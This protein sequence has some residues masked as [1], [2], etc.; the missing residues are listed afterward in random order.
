[1]TA[2]IKTWSPYQIDI[3]NFVENDSRNGIVEAVAGSGKSATIKEAFKRVRG[4]AIF[5]AFNKSIADE[6]KAAGVNGRTFHSLCMMPVMRSRGARDPEMN[7]L[8]RLCDENFTGEE[9]RLYGAFAQRLVG[10]ARQV[11]I[12][13]LVP[14]T[15]FAWIEICEH[16]AIE[17]ESEEAEFGKG[18]EVARR[19]LDLSNASKMVDFDDMLYFAVKDGIALPKFDFVFV[20]EAQDTNAIQRAILRKIM[21]PGARLVAVGDPAQ[22]I[23]GFRGADSESLNQIALDFNAVRLP[24]TITYRCPTSVVTYAQ[25]WVPHIEAAPGKEEGLVAEHGCDWDTSIFRAADLVVCRKSAP[26]IT[27][28]FR[29]IRAKVP[30]QVM[31]RDIGQG[32]KALIK[33]MNAKGVDQLAAKLEKFQEREV[34]KALAKKDE[35]KVEAIQDKVGSLLFLIEGLQETKRTIPDLENGIDYLF[36]DK[37]RAV[38]L[39]TIHKSKGLEADRVFWLNRSECPAKWARQQWQKDQEVNLCYVAA[40]RAKRELHMIELGE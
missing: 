1:M 10:L 27:L 20:D 19:L 6:L 26:L 37:D 29:C 11:G 17:P 15:E 8:R 5:L 32:L 13:C 28:A 33:K 4:E 9:V 12:G 35:A 31:G 34:E 39:A 18:I 25:Q 24:L 36:K 22:A 40:T 3:F 2:P 7:K 16:H 21:R 38:K 14:D 23:Y 30:V